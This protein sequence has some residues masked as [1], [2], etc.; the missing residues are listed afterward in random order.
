M[1]V[2]A[3]QGAPPPWLETQATVIA[4]RYQFARLHTL[5]L[6]IPTDDG[7]FLIAFN[8]SVHGKTYTDEFT[9]PTYL[10]QG[11]TF[12]IS[13]NPLAPRQNTRSTSH[14]STRAPLFATA[15]AGSI[16]LSVLYLAF[17]HG[18]N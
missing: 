17:L 7:S 16:L 14:S 5:T 10:E 2:S 3:P 18:C 1:T 8:Y 4:C 12:P 6:G 13:C 11:S 9:S 15:V